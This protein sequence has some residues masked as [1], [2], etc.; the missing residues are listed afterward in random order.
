MNEQ[1]NMFDSLDIEED[2]VNFEQAQ[3]ENE[4]EEDIRDIGRLSFSDLAI[5]GTD[6][7]VETI[8]SQ[9][10]KGNIKLDPSFQRRD[11]WPNKI[12]SRFID[13]EK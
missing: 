2:S 6:W 12:K 8:I 10:K 4:G 7:T 13:A 5:T 9:I 11:A 3:I 1:F